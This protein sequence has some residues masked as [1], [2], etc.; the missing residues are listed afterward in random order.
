MAQLQML[1]GEVEVKCS[2]DRI[3]E[4]IVAKKSDYPNLCSKV[5][6]STTLHHNDWTSVGC[7]RKWDFI[8]DGKS[9][10]V[11]EKVESIDEEN[12]IVR[13][14][15]VEGDNL[16]T[17]YKKLENKVQVIPKENSCCMVRITFEYEK[18]NEDAPPPHHLMELGLSCFKE[19]GSHLANC[20]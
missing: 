18:M 14:S 13:H 3:F 19:L 8:I 7:T 15:L 9:R 6:G 2:A 11:I 16:Q 17:H 20:N 1:E 10:Y 4:M 12:K 5:L